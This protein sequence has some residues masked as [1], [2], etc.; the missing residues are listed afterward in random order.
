MNF[1]LII[2]IG[3]LSYSL[4][5]VKDIVTFKLIDQKREHQQKIKF[6]KDPGIDL[7]KGEQTKTSSN[8][9]EHSMPSE[10]EFPDLVGK[11][12]EEAKSI[13]EGGGFDDIE[14]VQIVQDGMMVTMGK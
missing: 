3:A 4:F 2:L 13:I 1:L 12:G 9:K 8:P 11:T 14:L 6:G 7:I 5:K 10:S